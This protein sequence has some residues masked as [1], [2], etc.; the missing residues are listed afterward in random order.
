[1][2]QVLQ[3]VPGPPVQSKRLAQ[4]RGSAA[5]LDSCMCFADGD[6]GVKKTRLDSNAQLKACWDDAKQI[7][8]DTKDGQSNANSMIW[9]GPRTREMGPTILLLPDT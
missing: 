6:F 2:M 9:V 3:N 1:M 4:G 7:M 8:P 5:R